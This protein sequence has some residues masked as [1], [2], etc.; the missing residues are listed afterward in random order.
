MAFHLH[1]VFKTGIRTRADVEASAHSRSASELCLRA[2]WAVAGLDG[3]AGTESPLMGDRVQELCTLR[4]G[5]GSGPTFGAEG[6]VTWSWVHDNRME[7]GLVHAG[8]H[9]AAGLWAT[10]AR[11]ASAP[12]IP[13]AL[14]CGTPA[15]P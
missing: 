10:R 6:Q 2:V 14:R 8:P 9:P 15:P 11:P 3:S 13:G 7:R 1:F 12:E 4:K 5:P